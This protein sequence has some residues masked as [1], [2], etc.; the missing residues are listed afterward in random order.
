MKDRIILSFEESFSPTII[1]SQTWVGCIRLFQTVWVDANPQRSNNDAQ[2]TSECKQSKL[3][4]LWMYVLEL[5]Y[6]N[7]EYC[8]WQYEINTVILKCHVHDNY[9]LFSNNTLVESY[10]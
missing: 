4:V 10:F 8:I 1:A 3:P 5:N 2:V 7:L 9:P 6:R